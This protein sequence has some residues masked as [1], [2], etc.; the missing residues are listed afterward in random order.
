MLPWNN[1]DKEVKDGEYIAH[2]SSSNCSSYVKMGVTMQKNCGQLKQVFINIDDLV[3][4]CF[5]Y[6][7]QT[8][9]SV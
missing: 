3:Q 1:Y 9:K 8:Q 2:G 7:K 6:T 5:P 4:K